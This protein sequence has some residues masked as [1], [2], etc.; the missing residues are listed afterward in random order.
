MRSAMQPETGHLIADVLIIDDTIGNLKKKQ[1]LFGSTASLPWKIRIGAAGCVTISGRCIREGMGN[2]GGGGGGG[3]EGEGEGEG[4][5]LFA[6]ICGRHALL[7]L[8]LFLGADAGGAAGTAGLGISFSMGV[9]ITRNTTGGGAAIAGVGEG[10]GGAGVV[11]AS[12][13]FV[14]TP[15]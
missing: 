12:F 5:I 7:L 3:V 11:G 2:G 8:L 13:A 10:V 9:L 15:S 1:V 4:C 14:C 6:V